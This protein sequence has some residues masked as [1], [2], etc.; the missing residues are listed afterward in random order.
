MCTTEHLND[1]ETFL[2]DLYTTRI[3]YPPCVITRSLVVDSIVILRSIVY[4]QKTD[5][6]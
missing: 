2:L 5:N 6:V 1:F 3:Y 4:N